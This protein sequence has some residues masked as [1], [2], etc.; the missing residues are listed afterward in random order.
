[1][2]PALVVDE[3]AIREQAYYFWEQ[4]GRPDGEGRLELRSGE[5]FSG[6]FVGG[7]VAESLVTIVCKIAAM[8]A[9]ANTSVIL[10]MKTQ[11]NSVNNRKNA[12]GSNML[13]PSATTVP[14]RPTKRDVPRRSMSERN[15]S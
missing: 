5:V 15:P 6:T 1:M 10:P 7:Q 12:A 4:D 8:I 14:D 13:I 3:A 9:P 11:L 2:A